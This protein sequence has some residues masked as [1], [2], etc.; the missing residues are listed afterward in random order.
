MEGI[1]D[2]EY[3]F[4]LVLRQRYTEDILRKKLD[5]VGVP[6]YQSTQCI[7]YKIDEGAPFDSHGVTSV[8]NDKVT[9]GTFELKRYFYLF[10][11]QGRSLLTCDSK[12]IVGADGSRS[13]VRTKAGIPFE[14]DSTE[15]VW[16]RVDGLVET[17]MP[18]TR[19]YG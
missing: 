12:Y 9:G 19:S 15:D 11:G 1:K 5:S 13:F 6:H 4:A 7:D 3:D 16:I 18:I 8:F 17:D 14:G 2:T 10:W